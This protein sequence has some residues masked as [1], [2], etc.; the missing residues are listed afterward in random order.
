MNYLTKETLEKLKQKLKNLKEVKRKEIAQ[1]LKRAISF[2]DLSENAAYEEAKEAQAFLEGE[3]LELEN[4]IRKAKIIKPGAKKGKVIIG[5][6]VSLQNKG[7]R[8]E[9][10]EGEKTGFQIVSSVEANPSKGKISAESPLGKALL[11]KKKGDKI[12][13]K[14][15]EGKI[16][17]QILKI[18]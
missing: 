18:E 17:Y 7:T 5:S 6:K 4:L 9:L 12:Q 3:I 11:G 2:G 10:A 8:P 14:T 15:P 1:R 16:E 13:V